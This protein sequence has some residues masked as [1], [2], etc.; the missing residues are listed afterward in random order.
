M[1]IFSVDS[2]LHLRRLRREGWV[3]HPW[4]TDILAALG[5][6]GWIVENV[7]SPP[8]GGRDLEGGSGGGGSCKI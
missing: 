2:F 7:G 4:K 1:H 6:E 5:G 8:S 3:R